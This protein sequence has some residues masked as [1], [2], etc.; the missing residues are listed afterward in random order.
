MVIKTTRL[1]AGVKTKMKEI[2]AADENGI[3]TAEN[4]ALCKDWIMANCK[5]QAERNTALFGLWTWCKSSLK[6]EKTIQSK[7]KAKDDD[8]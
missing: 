8:I 7:E 5:S 2:C 6:A 3:I 1:R 4:A